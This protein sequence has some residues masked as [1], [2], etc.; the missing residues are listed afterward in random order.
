MTVAFGVERSG[1]RAF[2]LEG[3]L[4][5]ETAPLLRETVWPALIPSEHLRLD[6]RGLTFIGSDGL[7]VLIEFC[8]T[9]DPGHVI[10]LNAQTQVQH[11]LRLTGVLRSSNLI[12]GWGDLTLSLASSSPAS[13]SKDE[14]G[15]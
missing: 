13:R 11:V 12:L 7:R 4:D 15:P 6:L 9:I 1:D 2:T 10:L 5:L 8:Q 3:E 14:G